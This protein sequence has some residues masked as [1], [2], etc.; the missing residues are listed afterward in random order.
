MPAMSEAEWKAFI[1]AGTRTARLATTRADGRPHVVPVW[2]VLDGD[3]LIFTTGEKTV[4]GRN[5]Q[6]D[7]RVALCVD[8]DAPPF[9][10]VMI[11]G[12]ARLEHA[13]PDL[14]AWSTRIASRYMGA[15]QG[16]AYGKRN[17][18]PGEMLVRVTPVHVIAENDIAGW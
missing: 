9:A 4:K 16:D 8:D 5:L 10:Y 2:F 3:D 12:T 18:V 15:E 17:A 13:A 1:A 6:R 7:A 11:E 14:L